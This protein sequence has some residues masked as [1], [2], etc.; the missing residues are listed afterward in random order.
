MLKPCLRIAV[1]FFCWSILHRIADSDIIFLDL[2]LLIRI[3]WWD[4]AL[5]ASGPISGWLCFCRAPWMWW[6]W[7]RSVSSMFNAANVWNEIL[8]CQ[9]LP[10]MSLECFHR[11]AWETH[12][13]S[14][15]SLA[16][17]ENVRINFD[18]VHQSSTQSFCQVWFYVWSGWN[19]AIGARAA[20]LPLRLFPTHGLW[21]FSR[22]GEDRKLMIVRRQVLP[23]IPE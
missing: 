9:T 16:I 10:E 19:L 23:S 8:N 14:W 22:C 7:F 6:I 3:Y 20:T 13:L 18:G 5:Q 12:E 1:Q 15:T 2:F 11:S 4:G 17:A 21:C